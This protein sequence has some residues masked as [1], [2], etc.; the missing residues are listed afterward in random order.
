MNPSPKQ[1]TNRPRARRLVDIFS[2]IE[3]G[4]PRGFVH[5]SEV[6]PNVIRQLEKDYG[7]GL[8]RSQTKQNKVE[9]SSGELTN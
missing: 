7:Q 3:R 9:E 6:L 8:S 4:A 1:N 5:I 2:S